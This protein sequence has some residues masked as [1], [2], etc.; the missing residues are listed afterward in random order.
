MQSVI[1]HEINEEATTVQQVADGGKGNDQEEG[2]SLLFPPYSHSG[3]N[4]HKRE[5]EPQ[6]MEISQSPQKKGTVYDDA[7]AE[8]DAGI[9]AWGG[10]G[11]PSTAAK[12]P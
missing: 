3:R 6:E 8:K 11:W 9:L 10:G 4:N 12:S 2:G 5:K 7:F 1:I